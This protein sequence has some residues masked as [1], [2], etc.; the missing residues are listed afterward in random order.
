MGWYGHCSHLFQ[1]HEKAVHNRQHCSDHSVYIVD[2]I[3]V[4]AQR[5]LVG[6]HRISTVWQSKTFAHVRNIAD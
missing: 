3:V 4:S 6:N 1:E 2:N 5:T